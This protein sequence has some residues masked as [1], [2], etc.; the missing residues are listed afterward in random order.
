MRDGTMII[1]NDGNS[2][3]GTKNILNGDSETVRI[4]VNDAR[5]H[6]THLHLPPITS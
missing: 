4:V 6:I 2:N 3:L 5:E 1:N